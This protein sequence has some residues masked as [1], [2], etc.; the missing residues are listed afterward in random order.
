MKTKTG[1]RNTSDSK[2]SKKEFK[3]DRQAYQDGYKDG[4]KVMKNTITGELEN[5]PGIGPKLSTDIY[6]LIYNIY[7]DKLNKRN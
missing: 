1:I 4:L 6:E 5:I 7:Q 2:K 3:K